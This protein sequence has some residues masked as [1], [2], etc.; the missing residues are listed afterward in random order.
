M[1]TAR[2]LVSRL[3][4]VTGGGSGIGRAVCQRLASEGASV[5]VADINEASANETL[6]SLPSDLRGQA[7]M[8]AAA[9][10]ASKESVKTLL[11]SIQAR[12][13]QPPSVCVNA[14]GITL[15]NFLLD[16][17]EE[18]FDKGS[19]L[20]I[21]AVAQA[22]VACGAT[23]GSI[24]TLGSIVGKVGNIGQVNYAASK[25]GVQ[26]L[27]MTAAKELSRF[28][29][30]CNC[31]LPGFISTP[32]TDAVPEKVISKMKALIPLRRMGEATEV[33]DVCAF[34]ASDDSRYVT[35][36]SLEVTGGLFMG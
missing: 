20:V 36:T 5:V 9:N 23:K 30:R 21:Q 6:Q 24:I 8:A 32:M 31:V 34:L 29:I 28:G 25:S 18:D 35:G 7:H 10:V 27:T 2:R 17:E 11:T 33:A 15:D 26:G 1:A 3:A 14:A 13:F 16:M 12:Y 4:V 22:L 19:F